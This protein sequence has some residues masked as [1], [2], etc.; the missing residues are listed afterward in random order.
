VGRIVT[1]TGGVLAEADVFNREAKTTVPKL[2][3]KVGDVIDFVID[4]KANNGY[5][6]FTWKVSITLTPAGRP[7]EAFG[8]D[9]VEDFRGP[10]PA[11][12]PPLT[13]REKLAQVLLMSNEFLYVD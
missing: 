13:P 3:V 4:P 5:D 10:P 6:S 1:A 7:A 11:V 8:Y 9:S 2:A 12:G